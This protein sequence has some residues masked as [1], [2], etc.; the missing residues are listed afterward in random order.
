MS[1]TVAWTLSPSTCTVPS[2]ISGTITGIGATQVV[3]DPNGQLGTLP[4]SRRYKED[5]ADMGDASSGLLRLRPVV[6]RYRQPYRDGS[7]P[8]DYGL[9]AEEV[10][11]VF[12]DLVVKRDDGQVETVQYQK[13]VPMLLNE[14]QKQYRRTEEQRDNLLHQNEEIAAQREEIADLKARL[15]ALERLPIGR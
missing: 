9:I 10:A 7:K 14:V 2:D 8:I 11:D 1:R 6:F 15:A 13:L 5:I 3:I 4:S 12:P